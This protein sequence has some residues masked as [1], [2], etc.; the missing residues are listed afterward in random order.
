MFDEDDNNNIL[1]TIY[2]ETFTIAKNNTAKIEQT[3]NDFQLAVL[4]GQQLAFK[5]TCNSLY[6]QVGATTSPICFKELA[7]STTA[8]GRRMV[9]IARD[10]TINNFKGIKLVYGD[11][12]VGDEP[13]LLR[14][15]N[16]QVEIKTIEELADEW[17]PYEE[18]KPFDTNRKE[19]EQSKTDY[20]VWSN[21]KW[22]KIK[23]V[24]RHKTNKDIYR[25]NTHCGVVD[26]TE[27]HSLLDEKC[28]KLK[29]KDCIIGKTKL[30][31]SYPK[32]SN[33]IFKD[34]FYISFP[35]KLELAKKL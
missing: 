17:K 33:N 22:T 28:K 34:I 10:E 6:G 14:N 1:K 31:Q 9:I 29:P 4:N 21:N 19:K 35:S 16:K 7:A 8:T 24:M 26:V 5:I 32:L 12:I 3:F 30:L 20:E 2:G 13:L 15:K 18:F 25:V 23:R 11:S 27:D